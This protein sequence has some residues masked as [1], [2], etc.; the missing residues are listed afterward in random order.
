LGWLHVL[1]SIFIKA[2]LLVLMCPTPGWMRVP[3]KVNIFV[4]YLLRYRLPTI[5]NLIRRRVLQQNTF[6]WYDIYN[7]LGLVSTKPTHV[8][9]HI[10]QFWSLDGFSKTISSAFYLIWLS[11]DWTIWHYAN[12][13]VFQKENSI[14]QR[15]DK[16]K[17]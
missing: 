12:T 11:C 1:R 2:C 8:H 6:F 9:D 5:D 7:W 3:L 4:W 15:I 16:S 13:R 10:L 14:N 17:L